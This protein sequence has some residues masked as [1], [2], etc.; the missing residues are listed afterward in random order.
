[1]SPTEALQR[2]PY[3]TLLGIGGSAGELQSLIGCTI[4]VLLAADRHDLHVRVRRDVIALPRP[5]EGSA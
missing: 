4:A 2:R 3:R 5:A 1:M